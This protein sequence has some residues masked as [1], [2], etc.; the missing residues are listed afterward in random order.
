M[1]VACLKIMEDAYQ[2][3]VD[4]KHGRH[5][6]GCN[7]DT[8]CQELKQNRHLLLYTAVTATALVWMVN[9]HKCLAHIT[10][11]SADSLQV[12]C[13]LSFYVQQL[14][15]LP[16]PQV[17]AHTH[18]TGQQSCQERKRCW[19]HLWMQQQAPVLYTNTSDSCCRHIRC[20]G[21]WTEHQPIHH[22]VSSCM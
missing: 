18:T 15:Q 11:I 21:S 10:A 16:P 3:A 6:L 12:A 14:A 20:V 13:H 2:A 19:E 22:K 5:V 8:S 9:D 4:D 17:Q 7:A 1:Q